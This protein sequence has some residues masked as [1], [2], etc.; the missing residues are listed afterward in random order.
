MGRKAKQIFLDEEEYK[1][2]K[3]WERSGKTE[4]RLS[5]RAKVILLSSQG[6]TLKDISGKTGLS[7]QNC[8]KWRARFQREG[9]EGLKDKGRS[10][11]PS[12]INP[13]K[14]ASVIALACSKPPDG[15]TVWSC[16]KLAKKTGLGVATIHRILN[17]GQI[18]PHKV[19]YWC[20]RSN[21]PEFEEKQAAIIGLYLNPPENAVVLAI[22][23]KSQIQALDRTQ[24]MLPMREG[25]PK[26]LTATYK[27]HGTTC[28]LAS[29]AVH[30]GRIDGRCVERQTHEEFLNFLKHLYRQYPNK[31]LHVIVDN[32]SAHKHDK[33]MKW[34]NA[35]R[36]L[37][38]HFTPTYAS[39]LNQVE[40]WFNIFSRDVLKGG[41][42]HSKRELVKQIMDYIKYYNKKRAKPFKWTYTGKP[43]AA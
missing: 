18:K 29:L 40:I 12:I 6:I 35:K 37:T 17:G 39:W 5:Q 22:D 2:L 43:L 23:E 14:K 42:W 15:N 9:I 7:W 16:R 28:L 19:K 10:G 8:L 41:V 33:V 30:E 32:L 11:R 31:H 4:Q 13:K 27:R 26:R 36:R 34:V 38:L 21:D 3:M 20:G 24:P 25:N 1:T